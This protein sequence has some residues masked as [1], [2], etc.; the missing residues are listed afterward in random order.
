MQN[1]PLV[2]LDMESKTWHRGFMKKMLQKDEKYNVFQNDPLVIFCMESKAILSGSKCV[3][4][5]EEKKYLF[6]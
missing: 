3:E 1:Y 4:N 2:I 6:V 5:F